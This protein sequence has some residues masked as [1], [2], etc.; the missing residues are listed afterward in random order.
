MRHLPSHRQHPVW[1]FLLH[2]LRHTYYTT[3]FWLRSLAGSLLVTI[4]AA[5]L[6]IGLAWLAAQGF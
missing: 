3:P 5:L 6:A 4:A 2:R 1:G